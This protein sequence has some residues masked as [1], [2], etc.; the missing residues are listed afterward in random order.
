MLDLVDVIM[1]DFLVSL[2]FKLLVFEI[3]VIECCR[4]NL[5]ICFLSIEPVTKRNFKSISFQLN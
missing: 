2:C 3:V 4:S 5:R 1:Y